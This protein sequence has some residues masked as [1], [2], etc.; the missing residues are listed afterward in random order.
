[1]LPTLCPDLRYGDLDGVQDGGMAMDAYLEASAPQAS[2]ERKA[3]STSA[4]PT[5]RLIP[6]PWY[7]CGRPLLAMR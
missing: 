2:V 6:L 1:M 5:V 7:E 3:R 4:T